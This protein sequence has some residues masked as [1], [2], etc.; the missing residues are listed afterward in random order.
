MDLRADQCKWIKLLVLPVTLCKSVLIPRRWLVL[1]CCCF[2]RFTFFVF[3]L[4][5]VFLASL[6]PFQFFVHLLGINW[7]FLVAW[8][9][10]C[11]MG[12]CSFSSFSSLSLLHPLLSASLKKGLILLG[13]KME[14]FQLHY[15]NFLHQ[16]SLTTGYC[17]IFNFPALFR[18][19][20]CGIKAQ[21]LPALVS[22]L[23]Y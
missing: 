11:G 16:K 4:C 21:M 2:P 1:F 10:I 17:G 5:L 7:S 6:L 23:L 15:Y 20:E 9:F 8:G 13:G 3:H 18:V 12:C 19:C 14:E 22:H